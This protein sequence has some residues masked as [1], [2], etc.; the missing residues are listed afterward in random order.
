MSEPMP[1]AAPRLRPDDHDPNDHRKK[2]YANLIGP[3]VKERRETLGLTQNQL[4]A[5]IALETNGR[6]NP[7][8]QEVTQIERRRRMV[9]DTEIVVL[10]ACLG[11]S[12]GWLMT[13]EGAP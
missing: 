2:D 10:A 6:W 12:V 11:V 3:R 13:G 5:R 4:T 1:K 7:T 8:D 9:I